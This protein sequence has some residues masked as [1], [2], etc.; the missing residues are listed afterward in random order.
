LILISQLAESQTDCVK[1]IS[2]GEDLYNSADYNS[3]VDVLTKALENC[4]YTTK[5]KEDVYKLLVKSNIEMD[6]YVQANYYTKKLLE[7]NPGYELDLANNPEDYILQIQKH[8]VHPLITIGVRDAFTTPSISTKRVFSI[9]PDVNYETEYVTFNTRS[10][11]KLINRYFAWFEY[12]PLPSTSFV[13]EIGYF[14]VRIER[15]LFKPGWTLNYNEKMSFIEIPVF[16]KQYFLL[17]KLINPYLVGGVCYQNQRRA[18]A[19][20]NISYS[21]ASFTAANQPTEISLAQI[22]VDMLPQRK[23]NT[24]AALFGAGIG[25]K[26]KNFGISADARY[27]YGINNLTKTSNRFYNSS[28]INDYFYIDNEVVLNK[29]ET[30]LSLSYTIKNLVKKKRNAY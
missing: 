26:Y 12:Q 11:A 7:N 21:N 6:N 27:Y 25:Y 10:T 19:D 3:A 5:Q 29:W 2:R 15:R 23:I 8:N 16:A 24:F 4:F 9:L 14:N 20:V 28:L 22:D 1:K 30:A 18:K 17:K 13:A